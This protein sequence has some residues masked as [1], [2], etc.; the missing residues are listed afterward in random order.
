MGRVSKIW[1]L[2]WIVQIAFVIATKDISTIICQYAFAFYTHSYLNY[3]KRVD[4]L[5]VSVAY[6]EQELLRCAQRT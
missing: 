4:F 1:S 5:H 3:M 2:I 6:D